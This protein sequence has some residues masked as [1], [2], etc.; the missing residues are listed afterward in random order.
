MCLIFIPLWPVQV[1]PCALWNIPQHGERAA[2]Q[3][4]LVQTLQ[5]SALDLRARGVNQK[6][7]IETTCA[8]TQTEQDSLMVRVEENEERVTYDAPAVLV[9]FVD[10]V[11]HQAHPKAPRMSRV[12]VGICHFCPAG[13][14]PIEILHLNT[15]NRAP[16]EEVPPPKDRILSAQPDQ[17]ADKSVQFTLLF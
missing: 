17:P 1:S 5:T 12:P 13:S 11:S 10:L 14:K 8:P 4:V 2:L 7:P 15:M 9:Y 3:Q 6:F 16:L